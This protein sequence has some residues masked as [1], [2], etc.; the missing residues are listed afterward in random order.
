MLCEDVTA[1]ELGALSHEFEKR[2]LTIR[3]KER[4]VRQIDD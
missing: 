4:Y 3:T 2:I 1:G